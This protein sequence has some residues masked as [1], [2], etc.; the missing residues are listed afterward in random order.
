MEDSLIIDLY[1]KR[2]EE[3]IKETDIKYHQYCENIGYHV[4]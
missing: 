2:S 1:F 3:A 4:N